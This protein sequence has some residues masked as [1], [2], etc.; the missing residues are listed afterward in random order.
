[1]L[2]RLSFWDLWNI[3]NKK[4]TFMRTHIRSDYDENGN[5]IYSCFGPTEYEPPDTIYEEWWKYDSSNF[6]IYFTNTH[7]LEHWYERDSSGRLI[8]VKHSTGYSAKIEYDLPN[9][10]VII[11][12]HTGKRIVRG[13]Y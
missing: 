2:F 1:M 9:N 3:R 6:C 13:L 7:K 4:L 8:S 5:L 12:E 11:T 10:Q